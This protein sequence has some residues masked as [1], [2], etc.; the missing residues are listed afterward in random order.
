M[1]LLTRVKAHLARRAEARRI[2]R[3]KAANGDVC[4]PHCSTWQSHCCQNAMTFGPHPT[5]PMLD[6]LTC[7]Q[8][9]QQ[10]PWLYGPGV[11]LYVGDHDPFKTVPTQG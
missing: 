2:Q 7:G 5:D 6:V 9:G 4:C 10:S 3:F 8:C 1:T 11:W